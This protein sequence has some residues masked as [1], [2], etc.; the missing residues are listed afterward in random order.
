MS[1]AKVDAHK[2]EKKNRQQEMQKAK[3]RRILVRVVLI[4][5]VIVIAFWVVFSIVRYYQANREITP[6]TVNMS[7]ITNYLNDQ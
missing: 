5:V 1:Q 2:E 6:I 3:H 4:L 7:A